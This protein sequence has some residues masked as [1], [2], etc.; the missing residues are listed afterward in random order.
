M[1]APVM[2]FICSPGMYMICEDMTYSFSIVWRLISISFCDSALGETNYHR[3]TD[4]IH[5]NGAALKAIIRLTVSKVYGNMVIFVNEDRPRMMRFG[6]LSSN[7]NLQ[8]QA[9]VVI[10][11]FWAR[12]R[13]WPSHLLGSL[14]YEREFQNRYSC[15]KI[16]HEKV[17]FVCNGL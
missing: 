14:Y 17:I 11:S 13:Q 3:Y 2:Y 9:A 10:F 15:C 4:E 7:C 12:S 5:L 6:L 8:L 16:N 1:V